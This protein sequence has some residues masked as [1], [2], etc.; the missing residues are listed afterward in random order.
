MLQNWLSCVGQIQMWNIVVS[1]CANL[2]DFA[3][4]TSFEMP[5]VPCFL[6]VVHLPKR[7]VCR[8]MKLCVCVCMLG[9]GWG[10]MSILNK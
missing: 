9:G 1:S 4:S 7:I 10:G 6:F 5:C 2:Q 8:Y 3:D